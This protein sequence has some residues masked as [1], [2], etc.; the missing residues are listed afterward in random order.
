MARRLPLTDAE[1]WRPVPGYEGVYSVSRA[2]KV[3][4][5]ARR[6]PACNGGTR[7]VRERLL[8]LIVCKRTRAV[9][10]GLSNEGKPIQHKVSRLVAQAF[11][12]DWDPTLEVY[13]ADGNPA[14]NNVDNLRMQPRGTGR[15]TSHRGRKQTNVADIPGE[16]WRAHPSL[17]VSASNYG[18]LRREPIIRSTPEYQRTLHGKPSSRQHRSPMSLRAS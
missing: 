2:G 7:Q 5:E 15:D 1:T 3:R 17:P 9:F 18:R 8:S 14:N 6:V 13:H 16:E 10:V 12:A 11:L 4:S